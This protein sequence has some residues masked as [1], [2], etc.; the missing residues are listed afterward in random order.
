MRAPSFEHFAIGFLS[1]QL[2]LCLL[3]LV[4]L[5]CVLFSD[6]FLTHWLFSTHTKECVL[7][8]RCSVTRDDLTR[9]N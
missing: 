5:T 7:F 4:S 3:V 1:F 8:F 9:L 6:S 2:L